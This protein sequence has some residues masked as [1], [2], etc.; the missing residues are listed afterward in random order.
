VERADLLFAE[1]RWEEAASAYQSLPEGA[2]AWRPYGNWRAA[3]IFRDALQDPGR[4]EEAF[5]LCSRSYPEEK[6]GYV[7]RVDLGDLRRD[8]GEPR[9]AIDAYR[10]AL[11]L[12]PKGSYAEHCLLESGRAYLTLG[13]PSQARVEWEELL[14]S[15]PK[16]RLAPEVGL[17]LA[18]SYDLQRD[19]KPALEAYRQVKRRFPQDKVSVL[20][21]F[22]EGET[23]E[24]MGRLVEAKEVFEALRDSHPNARGVEIKLE[25]L[26]DRI[27]RRTQNQTPVIDGGRVLNAGPSWN[28]DLPAQK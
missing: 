12:R 27:R 24:Q 2:G 9:G 18:R 11:E 20:A 15:F 19:H 8:T 13:A 14:S 21:A 1:S 28:T 4:A 6:W 26:V 16:S 22:G 3:T 5:D 17:E 23:L 10:G 25:A 7:C